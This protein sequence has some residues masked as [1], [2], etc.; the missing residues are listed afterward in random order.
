LEEQS[1][2][3]VFRSSVIS[4]DELMP[5]SVVDFIKFDVEGAEVPAVMGARQLIQRSRPVLV[6]SLYHRPADLWEIPA[7][8]ASLCPNYNFYIRQHF[9]NSFDSV[10]YAIP[11]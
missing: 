1:G 6:L 5:N 4:L 9:N 11:E 10:F 7:L 3:I 8:I 2:T